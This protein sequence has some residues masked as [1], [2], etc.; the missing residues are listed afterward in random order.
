ML[1]A[2]YFVG[3][4]TSNTG[5]V[6][7]VSENKIIDVLKYPNRIYDKGQEK[8]IDSKIKLLE[9]QPR[10]ATK[11]KALKA[12]KKALKRRATRDY[13]SIYDFLKKYKENIDLVIIEE[14]IRQIAGM[15]TSIDAIFANAMTFGVYLTICSI[16]GL[17]VRLFSPTEWHKYFQYDIKGKTNKDK[18][19]AIKEQSIDFCRAI[20]ENSDDFLIKKGCKK[21]DDNIAEA[22]LLGIIGEGLESV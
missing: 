18:R 14:P 3:I 7:I 4:D 9:K 22:C 8:I 19:E 10:T 1:K 17:K 20:F 6:A 15:A 13:K 2:K 12:E 21:P 5:A 16:L 11:I